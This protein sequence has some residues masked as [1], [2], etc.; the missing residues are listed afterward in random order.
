M[1]SRERFNETSLSDKKAFY[2]ELYL[3]NITNKKLFKT[4][5][6]CLKMYLKTLETSV[7]KYMNLIPLISCL[8]PD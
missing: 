3:K 8:H 6:Y 2:S 1:D 4:I 7:L 5:H